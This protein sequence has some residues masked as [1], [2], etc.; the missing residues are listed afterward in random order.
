MQPDTIPNPGSR[1]ARDKGCA[2]P[3]IDNGYGRGYR[4]APGTETQFVI[5]PD[6]PLHG[7]QGGPDAA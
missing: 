4:Y 7:A 5:H 3:V 2:C 6:C 1:E